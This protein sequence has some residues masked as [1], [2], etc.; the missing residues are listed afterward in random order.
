M[1]ERPYRVLSRRW[2]PQR[3]PP[4]GLGRAGSLHSL[5]PALSPAGSLQRP[6]SQNRERERRSSETLKCFTDSSPGSLS[7]TPKLPQD[8]RVCRCCFPSQVPQVFPAFPP[9]APGTSGAQHPSTGAAWSFIWFRT[10]FSIRERVGLQF[11]TSWSL[12]QPTATSRVEIEVS[13]SEF[14]PVGSP[15]G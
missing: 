8:L 11:S 9:R 2:A 6:L 3:A 5:A 1:R 12:Q 10:R 7:A 14:Q 4:G 15:C 13:L